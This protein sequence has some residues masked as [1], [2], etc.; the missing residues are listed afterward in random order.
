[1][2]EHKNLC[3]KPMSKM[4]LHYVWG[5]LTRKQTVVEYHDQFRPLKDDIYNENVAEM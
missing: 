4:T 5:H 3:Q 1:M 2:K